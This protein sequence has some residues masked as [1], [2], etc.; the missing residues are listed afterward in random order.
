M[1][2]SLGVDYAQG[3]GVA[4]P[5]RGVEVGCCLRQWLV[6]VERACDDEAEGS[7]GVCVLEVMRLVRQI[8]ERFSCVLDR[9]RAVAECQFEAAFE[10]VA[11]ALRRMLMQLGGGGGGNSI[12]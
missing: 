1:L 6:F 5:Q 7:R 12:R 3:Y 2:T 9:W 10:H 4:Q 8:D 11:D